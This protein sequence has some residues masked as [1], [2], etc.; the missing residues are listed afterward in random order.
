MKAN[1]IEFFDYA[2][3][4][5]L[6]AEAKLDAAGFP[7]PLTSRESW[8][9][10]LGS[11]HSKLVVG[12]RGDREAVVGVGL[13]MARVRSAPGYFFA[14][15]HAVGE[16][17]ATLEGELL[18]EAIARFAELHGRILRVTVELECRTDLSREF[19]QYRLMT[20]GFRRVPTKK[21]PARTLALDLGPPV[22]EILAGFPGS[23]RYELRKA[24]RLGVSVVPIF[25]PVYG[26]R[27]N[28][29]LAATFARTGTAVTGANWSAIM[30]VCREVPQRSRLVGVFVGSERTAESL[31]AYGWSIHH[32]DR[33][34]YHTSASAK[35]PGVKAPLMYP[36]LWE[37]IKWAKEQGANWFDFGGVTTGTTNSDD[38]LG[39]ISD[40]KRRFCREEITFGEEWTYEPV[41][42]GLAIQRGISNLVRRI[43]ELRRQIP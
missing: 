39:R 38:P 5:A 36:A 11:K 28:A 26:P 23:T 4:R 37:L 22:E 31:L 30:A 12:F 6:A 3:E 14:V 43:R 40:F 19:L 42:A 7:L 35:S 17:Y 27:M 25:D 10:H 34:A 16:S 18:L 32:G 33:A 24:E 9:R 41:G 13:E 21:I 29:L 20:N 8:N 15:V 2:D 1:T